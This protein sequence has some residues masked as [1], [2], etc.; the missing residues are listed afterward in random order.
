MK[1]DMTKA[2]G[3]FE[4]ATCG[5]V[6]TERCGESVTERRLHAHFDEGKHWFESLFSIQ[7]AHLSIA[8]ALFEETFFV[9]RGF[10]SA[11]S[12]NCC[13]GQLSHYRHFRH[14]S[15]ARVSVQPLTQ[16]VRQ[17]SKCYIA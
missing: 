10:A 11:L 8:L 2:R 17:R 15:L 13:C 1:F 9:T 4:R 6:L 5:N 7:C 16:S 3:R 14:G 12:L